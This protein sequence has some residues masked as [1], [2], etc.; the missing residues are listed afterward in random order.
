M[1]KN[2]S[3]H[4]LIE[5]IFNIFCGIII[6]SVGVSIIKSVGIITGGTAGISLI[7]SYITEINFGV[8]Y[9]LISAP[10]FI[11]SLIKLGLKFTIMT[12]FSITM[13]SFIIDNLK[14][15]IQLN[16]YSMFICSLF[17]G[18]LI[19]VALL[20]LSRHRASL[21]GFYILGI[22]LQDRNIMS[23]GKLALI[24][25][26]IIMSFGYYFLNFELILFSLLTTIIYN[27]FLMVN[28]RAGRYLPNE[29][30]NKE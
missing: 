17:G 15:S 11:I 27:L 10:F 14:L 25:D 8:W 20:G 26:C 1:N 29:I 9:I 24:S 5:D 28:H 30:N 3:G 22:Y 4:S 23:M 6:F 18:I 21:G 16:S 19:G 2:K 7:L 12:I 13:S